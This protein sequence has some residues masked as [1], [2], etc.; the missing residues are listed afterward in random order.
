MMLS[1][2]AAASSFSLSQTCSDIWFGNRYPALV[3]TDMA[4]CWLRNEYS[5]RLIITKVEHV[6]T[7]WNTILFHLVYGS[8]IYRP[9]CVFPY[10]K[11]RRN[12]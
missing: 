12:Y 1:L 3:R 11:L 2:D 10:T 5:I 8:T 4:D 6:V 7:H 9:V